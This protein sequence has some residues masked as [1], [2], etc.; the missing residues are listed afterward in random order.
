MKAIKVSSRVGQLVLD[1][2]AGSGSTMAAAHK[3]ERKAYLCEL[4]PIYCDVIIKRFETITGKKAQK[5]KK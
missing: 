4:D 1:L 2:F 5:L 3:L